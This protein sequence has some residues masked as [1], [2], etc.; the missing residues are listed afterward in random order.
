MKMGQEK[1]QWCQNS[2]GQLRKIYY[3]AAQVLPF[4]NGAFGTISRNLSVTQNTLGIHDLIGS[5]QVAELLGTTHVL[6]NVLCL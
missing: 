1:I 6:K 5:V 4:G 3:A 2:A